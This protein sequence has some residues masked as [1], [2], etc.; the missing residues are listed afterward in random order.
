MIITDQDPAMTKAI[1]EALPHTFH[2]FCSWHILNKF[3]KKLDGLKYQKYYQIFHSCICNSNSAEEF[4]S[5]WTEI[6]E[7]N[8][9]SDNTWLESI[10]KIRSSW[11]PTLV[12]HC[13]SARMSTSQRVD[14]QHSFFK[15][16]VFE[17]NLLV[18][19][20]VHF[21]RELLHQRHNELE[22][23]DDHINIEEKPKTAMSL[24][25]EDHMAKVYTRKFFY[26]VQEQLKESFKYKLELVREN[27]TH[28]VFKVI[29]KNIDTCKFRELTSEKESDFASC[30]C[31]KWESERVPYRHVLSYLIKIQDVDKLPIQYIIKRWTKAARQKFVFDSDGLEIKDHI[32]HFN[33]FD[34]KISDLNRIKG[35]LVFSAKAF[36]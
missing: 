25:I 18:D 3:S 27:V 6:I 14:S 8:G 17:L 20:V 7:N 1:T 12:N 34:F 29:R 22:E 33:P 30:R 10:Y 23:D 16:Y 21:K 19:F 4:D 28:C 15:N 32:F 36:F 11:I 35:I 9:L 2:R 24:D 5:R 26:E 13:F 31:R